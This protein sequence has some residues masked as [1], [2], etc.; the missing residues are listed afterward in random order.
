MK[1]N[2]TDT[3]PVAS[4]KNVVWSARVVGFSCAVLLL[5]RFISSYFPKERL[6]GINHLGYFS[7]YFAIVITMGGLLLLVPKINQGLQ[8]ILKKRLDFVCRLTIQ[9]NKYL[10][11][12][13]ISFS[14]TVVFWLLRVKAPFL[15]DGYHLITAL[16]TGKIIRIWEPLET[17]IHL[18]LYRFLTRFM[19]VDTMTIYASLSYLAGAIFIFF[20]L[21]T[22]DLIGKNK[23][24]KLFVLSILVSM[25]SI[26]LFLGYAEHYS[27]TYAGILAYLYLGLRYLERRGSIFSVTVIFILSC[28]LHLLTLSLFPSL[29]FLY[30]WRS[31][32]K[33]KELHISPKRIF[34]C[35]LLGLSTVVGIY[36]YI[37][38]YGKIGS[39]LTITVPLATAGSSRPYYSLLSPAHLL[40]ILNEQL[41]ISPVGLLLLTMVIMFSLNKTELKDKVFQF[42]A[43]VMFFGSSPI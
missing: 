32:A 25:G 14:S 6:W 27:L 38:K 21:L 20:A 31:D 36:I 29:V 5:S 40:D 7:P 43:V 22:S 3:L 4:D 30:L 41:L 24:E 28:F 11:F 17:A 19:A 16:P 39:L 9:R 37:M 1:E 13:L 23:F 26:L 18:H 35:S 10:Y 34:L 42:L 2:G 15:G 12:I 33:T 8:N